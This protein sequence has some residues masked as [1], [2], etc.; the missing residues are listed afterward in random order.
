MS[1]D[2]TKSLAYIAANRFGYGL[3]PGELDVIGKDPRAWLKNQL[4]TIN[5]IPV[6][7]QP[8]PTSQAMLT[9][10]GAWRRERR[11]LTRSADQQVLQD[12]QRDNRRKSLR[13]SR[14]QLSARLQVAVETDQPFAERLVRFW[15]NHFTVAVSGGQKAV[16]RTIAVPYENEAIRANLTADF[17]SLLL[18]VEKHP[19]MLIYLDNDNSIGPGSA[20]G[21]RRGRG[22]NENLAREIMELHAL[23]VDGGYTQSDV[24]SL[25]KM[26][27][28]WTVNWGQNRRPRVG[29][30]DTGKFQF[31]QPMHEPG[32]HVLLGE[33]YRGNGVRQGENALKDLAQHPATAKHIATKLVSHFVADEPPPLAVA[34]IEQV[35][36]ESR[37]SLPAIH[38]ALVDLDEIWQG[39]HKKLKT[40]EEYVVSAGRALG[41]NSNNQSSG[42]VYNSLSQTLTGLNHAPFTA[43]SPAGW[44]DDADHWGSPDALLKR[45]E[46]A[47]EIAERNSNRIN[48][49]DLYSAIM[50]EREQLKLAISRA[51]SPSQGLALLLGSPDFQ[52]R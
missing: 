2:S 41:V 42:R 14:E 5:Q 33:N 36:S 12:K 6:A 39:Q 50:P 43:N 10:E 13:Q 20:I 28:G 22:L 16:L 40:P 47:N 37:G 51:E 11:E 25:A 21:Q 19:A 1:S 32:N 44:P 48:P 18:A 3:R 38:E 7:M 31:A 29:N 26:I 9:E 17:T 8:L 45:I 27:T 49:S 4:K 23:S 35:F 30:Q 24:T 15:S 34:K 46:W 52:W